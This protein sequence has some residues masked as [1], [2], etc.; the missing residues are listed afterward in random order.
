MDGSDRSHIDSRP[1]YGEIEIVH[2]KK[3][4]YFRSELSPGL[5]GILKHYQYDTFVAVWND[6]TMRAD[7]YVRFVVDEN[8]EAS[9]IRMKG[10]DPRIDDSYDFRHLDLLPIGP[11]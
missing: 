5:N 10:F 11:D 1:G 2:E 6:R 9:R 8:G 3:N 4:L 7:A